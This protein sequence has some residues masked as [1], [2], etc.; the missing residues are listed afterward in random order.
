MVSFTVYSIR[1]LSAFVKAICKI[2]CSM[3]TFLC[4]CAAAL[5][6]GRFFIF[7]VRLAFVG[8]QDFLKVYYGHKGRDDL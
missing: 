1:S 2:L 5:P 7:G 8:T 4:A 3:S 6:C